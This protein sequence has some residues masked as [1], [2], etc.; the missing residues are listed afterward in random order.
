MRLG[1]QVN[2]LS[3]A[4]SS[5]SHP[6]F[7]ERIPAFFAFFRRGNSGSFILQTYCSSSPF[8]ARVQVNCALIIMKLSISIWICLSLFSATIFAQ[9]GLLPDAFARRMGRGLLRD[10]KLALQGITSRSTTKTKKELVKRDSKQQPLKAG[11]HCVAVQHEGLTPYVIPP[12]I[13]NTSSI[14]NHPTSTR[15]VSQSTTKGAV[16]TSTTIIPTA[17]TTTSAGSTSQPQPSPSATVAPSPWK[18]QT[19]MVSSAYPNASACLTVRKL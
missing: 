11:K 10:M 18:V 12:W 16:S 9:L 8:V 1:H 14:I 17:G 2:L 3:Y 13:W 7:Q 6:I 5:F 15:S 4:S 19:S